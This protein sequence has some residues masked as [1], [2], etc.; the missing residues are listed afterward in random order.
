MN[1]YYVTQAVEKNKNNKQKPLRLLKTTAATTTARRT[2][3]FIVESFT[4][5]HLNVQKTNARLKNYYRILRTPRVI[6][7]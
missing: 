1:A 5:S 7:V 2:T 4:P 3:V 6:V